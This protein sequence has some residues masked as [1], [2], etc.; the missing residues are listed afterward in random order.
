[1]PADHVADKHNGGKCGLHV[2]IDQARG[3]WAQQIG[4]E[5]RVSTNAKIRHRILAL[6]IECP[7]CGE[8]VSCAKC[9]V[10]GYT[11]VSIPHM[12]PEPTTPVPATPTPKHKPQSKDRERYEGKL[13]K[14]QGMLQE[15]REGRKHLEDQIAQIKTL[16]H[17]M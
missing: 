10:C 9:G 14:L 12:T 3:A 15:E 2:T 6:G 7:R 4:K 17:Q 13:L 16:V 5:E 11:G 1:M 8:A